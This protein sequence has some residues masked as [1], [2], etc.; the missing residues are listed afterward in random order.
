MRG[1]AAVFSAVLA[2]AATIVFTAPSAGAASKACARKACSDTTPPAVSF[3]APVPGAAVSGVVPVSGTSSDNVSVAS[4]AVNIDGGAWQAAS[5]TSSWSWSWNAAGVAA[6]GHTLGVRAVDTSGNART[7]TETVSVTTPDTAPPA[8]TIGSPTDGAAV[9]GT[10][11]VAG[12]SSD[13]AAVAKVEVAVDSGGWQPASGT[14]S[15]SWSWNTSGLSGGS[16]VVHARATD[17]SGNAATT[18]VS[19]TVQTAPADSTPPTVTVTAPAAG[20]SATGAVTVAGTSNDNTSVS[21]VDVSVDGGAWVR[22]SGTS[23][24]SWSWNTTTLSNGSHTVA[25]RATDSAGNS[26]QTSVSV[27]V[28]NTATCADG[29][30]LLQ[31]AVTAEGVT[32][33]I[34]TTVG[35]WTTDAINALLLPNA[36]DLSL[37]GKYITIEVQTTWASSESTSAACCKSGAYYNYGA[38]VYLNPSSNQTFSIYPD[39]IMAHE[40]GHVW[41]NYWRFM[42][43]ANSGSWDRYLSA[44]GVLGDSR[45]NTSYRWTPAE[46]AADDYRRLFG[47]PAAQSQLSYINSD[48]VDSQNV[49][50][51]A[52]FF[53][54]SWAVPTA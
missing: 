40:Y 13:N 3:A 53:T 19:L 54:N 35:G 45:V 26:A 12:T 5:G 22:A 41:T 24:W 49:A 2:T 18:S 15:W 11:A 1:S 47:T 21:A 38:G 43:P 46:M 33:K 39:A 9:S 32:I 7:A 6:G 29:T 28:S 23:S 44:R 31:K 36:R 25:A 30:P 51:L 42:N 8:V 52:T 16:H 14:A 34:C 10:V 27:T 17:S 37:I 48:V 50:G 4:V 20:S